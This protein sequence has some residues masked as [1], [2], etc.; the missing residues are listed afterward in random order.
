MTDPV[1]DYLA[2]YGVKGMRW[3]HHKSEEAVAERQVKR[4]AKAQ[5]FEGKAAALATKMEELQ[6]GKMSPG[7]V[8]R[9][10]ELDKERMT[11][12][13]DAE[14]KRNGKLTSKQKKVIVGASI[15]AGLVAAYVVQDQ[16]Q[17]GDV[18]RMI[19]KGREHFSGEKFDFKRDP[20]LAD[21]RHEDEI[22]E[23]IVKKVNPD[24]GK[25]GT[26]MNCRR[27]TFAYEMR[28]RGY[29]VQAT[30][31]TNGNGQTA[32]GLH[33]AVSPDRKG[34]D[35]RTGKIRTMTRFGKETFAT[36]DSEKPLTNLISNL[37]AGSKNK[38]PA[39]SRPENIFN[40]LKDQPDGSR[41]ELGVMWKMGGGHSMAY[42]IFNGKPIIFDAQSGKKLDTPE[43]FAKAMGSVRDAG[44]T[45]LDN[46]D[47]NQDYLMK[48]MKNA[49]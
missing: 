3:G 21:L 19:A 29:D 8:A 47:L 18:T 22:H 44:F 14:A 30:K 49:K 48:W 10:Q 4:E 41:G 40:A 9:I 31:T 24:Y 38:I 2:H 1:D 26:K 7:R 12:L 13:S 15:A 32:M 5:A 6:M 39:A 33:N 20:K 25:I 46:I 35:L 27:A 28:R 37:D 36:D 45:R 34:K 11:A 23:K 16:I 43:A 42:E 17:S